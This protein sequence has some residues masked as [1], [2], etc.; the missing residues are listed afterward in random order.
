PL[1]PPTV[2]ASAGLDSTAF[3][4]D[5]LTYDPSLVG[6]TPSLDPRPTNQVVELDSGALQFLDDQQDQA[7]VLANAHGQ[8]M[9]AVQRLETGIPAAPGENLE[10]KRLTE[11]GKSEGKRP[12]GLFHSTLAPQTADYH[13]LLLMYK[14][15]QLLGE[16]ADLDAFVSSVADLVMEEV[17]A[18]TVVVLTGDSK[19]E[20]T[21]RA[22]RHRGALDE[23]EVPISRGI[24]DLVLRTGSPVI[25]GDALHDERIVAGQSLALYNIR[26]M[27]AAPLLLKGEI[28][29]VL[30]LNR[31][32][33][34]PFSKAE[35]ELVSAIASLMTSGMDRAELRQHVSSERQRRRSLERFHPPEVVNQIAEGADSGVLREH[36]AT[37]LLCDI[38]GFEELA[39]EISPQELAQVLGDYY[40]LVYEKVFGNTGSLVKLYDGWALA[41]FG[42][43]ASKPKADKASAREAVWAIEAARQLI[44]EFS[45][46]T[47]LWPSSSHLKLT[48]AVA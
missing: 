13:A 4:P 37:V 41:L 5:D 16:A 2:E 17:N 35:G 43:H 18:N 27:L 31:A 48:C 22:I 12:T 25:S 9:E 21:P 26:A 47:S 3:T 29:G 14:V 45:A 15:S 19:T 24:I 10:K 8:I 44:D 39:K 6:P 36:N 23:G 1:A 34:I 33:P 46:L 7:E 28:R 30:Y 38:L 42:M 11:K 40:D 20:L 32:G